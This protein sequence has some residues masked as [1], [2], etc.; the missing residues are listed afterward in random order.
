MAA[1]FIRGSLTFTVSITFGLQCGSLS[2]VVQILHL[3][4]MDFLA[5]TT[6]LWAFQVEILNTDK[7]GLVMGSKPLSALEDI[8]LDSKPLAG[9]V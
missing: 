7:H 6:D 9:F 3:M 1:A 2:L 4:S 5:S 8:A